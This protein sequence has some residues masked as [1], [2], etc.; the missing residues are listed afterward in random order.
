MRMPENHQRAASLRFG[1]KEK[2]SQK[3]K[4]EGLRINK[5]SEVRITK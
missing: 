5:P 4:T 1:E 2:K 3:K